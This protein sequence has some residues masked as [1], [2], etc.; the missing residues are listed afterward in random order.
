MRRALMTLALTLI[1]RCDGPRP[2]LRA[3]APRA[4]D[5]R[6]TAPGDPRDAAPFDGGTSG[7]PGPPSDDDALHDATV[8]HEAGALAALAADGGIDLPPDPAPGRFAPNPYT[9]CQQADEGVPPILSMTPPEVPE[10]L[11]ATVAALRLHVARCYRCFHAERVEHVRAPD[12]SA[13]VAA[14]RAGG[15]AAMHAVGRFAYDEQHGRISVYERNATR[16]AARFGEEPHVGRFG[17]DTI[18]ASATIAPLLSSFDAVEVLP[19]ALAA[20]ERYVNCNPA[21]SS[22]VEPLLPWVEAMADSVGFEPIPT[23]PWVRPS[24]EEDHSQEVYDRVLFWHRWYL[25]H[26]REPLEAWRANALARNRRALAGRSLSA[27]VDAIRRL[28]LARTPPEDRE[29]ARLS[30]VQLLTDRRVPNAG[31]RHLRALAA[32]VGWSLDPPNDAGSV[33]VTAGQDASVTG[34]RPAGR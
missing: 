24:F 7:D 30:L 15:L 16:V 12:C 9:E 20:V 8:P 5:A 23:L 2:A 32:E 22:A 29:S 25:G 6:P 18:T 27:R 33:P 26:R 14:L 17:G 34:A 11:R 31:K 21:T 28:S 1:L 13:S 3:E 19:Y 10:A 4:T